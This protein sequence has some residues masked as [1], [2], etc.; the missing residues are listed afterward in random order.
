MKM[1]NRYIAFTIL[2]CPVVAFAGANDN[3]ILLD[4]SGDTLNLTID[5]I[6]YGNK[7]CGIKNGKK[8]LITL[9]GATTKYIRKQ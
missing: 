1:L 4:Q 9:T 8:A 5:Q 3:A 7:L 6:G 2:L